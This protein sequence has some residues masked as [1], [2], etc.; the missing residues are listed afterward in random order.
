MRVYNKW[1]PALTVCLLVGCNGRSASDTA[2]DTSP[3][4]DTSIF[5]LPLEPFD[6]ADVSP[7]PY[8]EPP[9]P[10][11]AIPPLRFTLDDVYEEGYEEG[12]AQG[13]EDAL[14]HRH[15]GYNYDD[16]NDYTGRKEDR[17]IEGY[18]DGYED[19]YSNRFELPDEF[20]E[21]DEYDY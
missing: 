14:L 15:H 21:D 4:E 20:E 2:V 6:T 11:P 1:I 7:G 19:G 8:V 13:E 10:Y 18:E 16:S 9:Q 12:Y 17:Y 3:V 5:E